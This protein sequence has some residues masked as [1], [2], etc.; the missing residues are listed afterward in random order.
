[1]VY[2]YMHYHKAARTLPSCDVPHQFLMNLWVRYS[3]PCS[4]L[5][6][7]HGESPLT[8]SCTTL[9]YPPEHVLLPMLLKQVAHVSSLA[10]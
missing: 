6:Q 3:A 10:N 8:S 9:D 1:M 4:V 2:R 7:P 5:Q